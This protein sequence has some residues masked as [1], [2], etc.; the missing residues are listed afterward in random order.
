MFKKKH[1]NGKKNDKRWKLVTLGYSEIHGAYWHL[2]TKGQ[3]LQR[4]RQLPQ[5]CQSPEGEERC[6]P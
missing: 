1:L 5:F 2:A 3:R 6:E 4:L